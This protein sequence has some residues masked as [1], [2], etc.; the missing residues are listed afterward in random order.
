MKGF[1]KYAN[2]SGRLYELGTWL[3]DILL[4]LYHVLFLSMMKIATQLKQVHV[5]FLM[6]LDKRY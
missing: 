2:W 6:K 4:E 1:N 5:K 3:A